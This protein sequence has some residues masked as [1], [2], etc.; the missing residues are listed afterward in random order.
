MECTSS[1][2]DVF[3]PSKTKIFRFQKIQILNIIR[4]LNIN[5]AHGY[6]DISIRMIKICYKSLL[7]PLILLF[8]NSCQ[9]S[10]YPDIWSRSNIIFAHKK[11]INN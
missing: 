10:C 8:K 2:R 3:D 6:D 9:S 1:K 7:K 4:A 11:V 5:K